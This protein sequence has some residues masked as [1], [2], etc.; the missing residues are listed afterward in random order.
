MATGTSGD[1]AARLILSD[2]SPYIRVLGGNGALSWAIYSTTT[3]EL[4][5]K[6]VQYIGSMGLYMQGDGNLVLYQGS[7]P[8]WDSGTPGQN[9]GTNQ[10][11]A[12][13][14]VDGASPPPVPAELRQLQREHTAILVQ[15]YVALRSALGT[16]GT[17]Q[18]DAY[19]NYEFVPHIKL[20][21]LSLPGQPAEQ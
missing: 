19:L 10:C 3:W 8:V 7:T 15:H 4:T 18:L 16:D 6:S 2:Q 13:F 14:Q 1:S 11:L 17:A 9:C 20:R 12:D 5:Q 21:R